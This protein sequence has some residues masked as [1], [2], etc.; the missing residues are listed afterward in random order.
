MLQG[1]RVYHISEL[2]TLHHQPQ[3]LKP[4][5]QKLPSLH[6]ETFENSRLNSEPHKK[7]EDSA[8]T[9][10]GGVSA[11]PTS[12]A[13]S[14]GRTSLSSLSSGFRVLVRPPNYHSQGFEGFQLSSKHGLAASMRGKKR[15][16]ARWS[17]THRTMLPS[18]HQDNPF[19]TLRGI[20]CSSKLPILSYRNAAEILSSLRSGRSGPK[21]PFVYMHVGCHQSWLGILLN[22]YGVCVAARS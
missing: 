13:N 20:G 2:H 5:N 16:R 17:Q 19:I 8:A 10:R 14:F 6:T 15:S 4:K 12:R 21:G 11:R 22:K 3:N 18:C 7:V 1:I 9:G